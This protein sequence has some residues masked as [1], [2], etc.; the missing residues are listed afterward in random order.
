MKYYLAFITL[1]YNI[2]LSYCK[3][4]E[5]PVARHDAKQCGTYLCSGLPTLASQYIQ[6]GCI[7]HFSD[8][9]QKSISTTTSEN[10]NLYVES[11]TVPIR[12]SDLYVNYITLAFLGT[13][14]V[15]SSTFIGYKYAHIDKVYQIKNNFF[16]KEY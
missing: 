8:Y 14:C 10:L 3:S 4:I 6:S 9:I 1:F 5:D 13:L 16:D 2:V 7:G 12:N 11:A 15:L